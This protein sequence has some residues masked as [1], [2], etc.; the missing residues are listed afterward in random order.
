MWGPQ[1]RCEL[2][3]LAPAGRYCAGRGDGAHPDTARSQL[4]LTDK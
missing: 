2:I 4:A 3:R 1:F